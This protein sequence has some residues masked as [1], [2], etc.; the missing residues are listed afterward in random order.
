[1]AKKIWEKNIQADERIEK[2]TVGHD[3]ELDVFLAR[4][5]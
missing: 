2:F 4:L 3:R 1:M 5:T